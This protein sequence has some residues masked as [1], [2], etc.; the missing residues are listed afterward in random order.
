MAWCWHNVS[1]KTRDNIITFCYKLLFLYRM[2]TAGKNFKVKTMERSE[3]CF[4][5]SMLLR[6]PKRWTLSF[7]NWI[8]FTILH[9]ISPVSI[10]MLSKTLCPILLIFRF[11]RTS[12]VIKSTARHITYT[13]I[14]SI[15]FIFYVSK[16]V[17][18]TCYWPLCNLYFRL[19]LH[20][21]TNIMCFT[22]CIIR[23]LTGEK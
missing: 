18:T 5:D 11:R 15:L 7:T 10:L 9:P 19:L 17:T 6:N 23:L 16:Y 21:Q 1:W 20:K 12:R 22:P 13:H 3:Q 2:R 8:Q 4:I 14:H